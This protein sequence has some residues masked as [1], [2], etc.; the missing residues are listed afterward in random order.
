VVTW[1]QRCAEFGLPGLEDPPRPGEPSPLPEALC[2][3]VRELTL[4][5]P[6]TQFG[7][8]RRSS[9]GAGLGTGGRG[10]SD[11]ARHH[12]PDLHRFDVQPWRTLTFTFSPDR[13]LRGQIREVV[14][15]YLHPP[16]RA[17]DALRRRE[18]VNSSAPAHRPTLPVRP[19]HPKTA[20]F[21]CVRRGTPTLLPRGRS[22]RAGSARPAPS[23][24]AARSSRPSS[25]RSSPP[26]RERHLVVDKLA[27]HEHP[28]VCASL[29]HHPRMRLHFTP[30]SG[31]GSHW[32]R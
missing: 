12:R 9:R 18:A 5:E 6:P 26:A 22:S 27:T 29:A 25:S 13:Q 2:D 31:R 24:T 14:G 4:T 20:S 16:E 19:G 23:G 21:D 30:T 3:R 11:L 7:A 17:G 28:A 15:L 10:D 1:R 8:T 32:S